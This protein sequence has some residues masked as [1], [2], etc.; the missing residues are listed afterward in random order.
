M[1]YDKK[2]Y[3][4]DCAFKYYGESIQDYCERNYKW[5]NYIGEYFGKKKSSF[6]PNKNGNCKFYKPRWWKFWLS[7]SKK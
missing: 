2:V 3:C 4:D 7:R 6:E 5:N 1:K